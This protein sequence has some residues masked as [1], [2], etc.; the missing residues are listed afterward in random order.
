[1]KGFH[2]IYDTTIDPFIAKLFFLFWIVI[3]AGIEEAI[4]V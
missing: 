3:Y 1:M 2:V 4:I